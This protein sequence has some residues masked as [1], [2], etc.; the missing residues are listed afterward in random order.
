MIGNSNCK[1]FGLAPIHDASSFGI[2]NMPR[3]YLQWTKFGKRVECEGPD[4]HVI[5][6]KEYKSN[7]QV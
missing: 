3:E 7:I 4:L 1:T 6:T 2:H 5:G